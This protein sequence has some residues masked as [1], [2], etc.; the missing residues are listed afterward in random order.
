MAVLEAFRI[1]SAVIVE[2]VNVVELAI[3][4]TELITKD[5]VKVVEA[6]ALAVPLS[7]M[8]NVVEP[9]SQYP[10]IFV[11]VIPKG[12]L[13]S[14]FFV[15]VALRS[16]IEIVLLRIVE[17]AQTP[18]VILGTPVHAAVEVAVPP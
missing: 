1:S 13:N 11:N 3:L 17:V 12:L 10:H 4:P 5:A 6:R 8:L 2:R 9:L 18:A 16:E 7:M 14:T 15:V